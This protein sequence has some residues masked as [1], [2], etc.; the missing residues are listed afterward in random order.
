M[1]RGLASSTSGP[2]AKDA[3]TLPRRQAVEE[4]E[5]EEAHGEWAEALYDYSS[6][7]SDL[8]PRGLVFYLE[9]RFFCRTLETLRWRR[10]RGFL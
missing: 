2:P 4:P 8:V 6:A 10:T 9:L 7:V 1:R 3:P 5:E